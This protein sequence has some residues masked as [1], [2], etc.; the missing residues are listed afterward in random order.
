MNPETERLLI[1]TLRRIERN[2]LNIEAKEI[3][4]MMTMDQLAPVLDSLGTNLTGVAAQLAKAQ[5]E[6]VDAIGRAGQTTPEV[7]AAVAKLTAITD[8]L[9]SAAQSLDDLNADL[10]PAP[11]PA[12]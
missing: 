11:A 2:T 3:D 7:D 4:I 10:P 8:A 6:I 9:K 5:Q 1:A 12:P